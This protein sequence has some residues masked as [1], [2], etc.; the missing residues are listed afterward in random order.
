MSLMPPTAFTRPA[1]C[2]ACGGVLVWANLR[3][4]CPRRTCEA[5]GTPMSVAD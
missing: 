5:H 2:E 1:E 3:L 4:V